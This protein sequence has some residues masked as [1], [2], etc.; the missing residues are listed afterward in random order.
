MKY[1]NHPD[2][3]AF[4]KEQLEP[5]FGKIVVEKPKESRAGEYTHAKFPGRL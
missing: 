5:R 2:L 1:F 4:R 3:N